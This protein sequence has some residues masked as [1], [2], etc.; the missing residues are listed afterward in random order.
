M[1]TPRTC[2]RCGCTEDRACHVNGVAC[3]W[4]GERL[5]SACARIDE[6]AG[7]ELG[8]EWAQLVLD[9]TRMLLACGYTPAGLV[10]TIEADLP[11]PF[12]NEV[13]P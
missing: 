13:N 7:D 2:L 6:L 11:A 1:T 4:V 8:I 12:A 9:H 3:C 10:R 5:C